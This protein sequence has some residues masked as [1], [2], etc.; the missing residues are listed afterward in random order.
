MFRQ[1]LIVV[2]ALLV[3]LTFI[4]QTNDFAFG[5]RVKKQAKF[6]VSI[7]NISDSEGLTAAYGSK[8]P[9]AV[10]LGLFVVTK[11]KIDFYRFHQKMF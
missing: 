9:I 6:I 11:N 7:E 5:K 2:T 4:M 8:Y 10:S 1:K 3:A